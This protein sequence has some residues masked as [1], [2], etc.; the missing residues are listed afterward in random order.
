MVFIKD[1]I[2]HLICETDQQISHWG[3]SSQSRMHF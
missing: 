1:I 3:I 2:Y